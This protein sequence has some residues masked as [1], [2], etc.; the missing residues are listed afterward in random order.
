MIFAF[1]SSLI[2]ALLT[3]VRAL[4]AYLKTIKEKRAKMHG[5]LVNL[6]L[7]KTISFDGEANSTNSKF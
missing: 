4:W 5:L 6:S 7:Q 3:I 1:G 2:T